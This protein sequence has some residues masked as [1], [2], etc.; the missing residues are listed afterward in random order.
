MAEPD[1]TQG[2]LHLCCACSL[3][4]H[5]DSGEGGRGWKGVTGCGE[6]IQSHSLLSSFLFCAQDSSLLQR[7]GSSLISSGGESPVSSYKLLHTSHFSWIL[8][9]L[10]DLRQSWPMAF[11]LNASLTN[12]QKL[13]GTVLRRI[14]RPGWDPLGKL[15]GCVYKDV[16]RRGETSARGFPSPG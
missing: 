10:E 7:R 12:Q 13:P 4:G 8:S 14:L 15:A 16:S 2:H 6:T 3:N 9:E 1:W 11:T 5:H